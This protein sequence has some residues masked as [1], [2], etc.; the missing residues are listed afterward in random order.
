[1]PARHDP[2]GT[3]TADALVDEM[4]NAPHAIR[5]AI[6]FVRYGDIDVP[7]RI[8]DIPEAGAC[9]GA[10]LVV[11]FHGGFN[12]NVPY[13]FFY[14]QRFAGTEDAPPRTV[15]AL[16]DPTLAVNDTLRFGWFAGRAGFDVPA[17]VHALL[18]E[19]IGGIGPSRT[20]FAGGSIG[21]H[22]ALRHVGAFP[23]AV[24]VGLN[25][26]PRIS[27]YY[28]AGV[29]DFLRTCWP[30]QYD[31]ATLTSQYV[32][33][34]TGDRYD[35]VALTN[36]F[37]IVQNP[38]DPHLYQQAL[39]LLQKLGRNPATAGRVLGV[40]PYM[41]GCAGHGVPKGM[42]EQW[43]EAAIRAPGTSP[44]TIALTHDRLTRAEALPAAETVSATFGIDKQLAREIAARA[45]AWTSNV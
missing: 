22:A 36:D 5:R 10:P 32:E 8:M 23:D 13:P 2:P 37:V 45:S 31:A 4:R 19:V 43:V 6:R 30:G 7:V 35:G 16:C 11:V 9:S 24:F 18:R 1:M 29:E 17:A 34:D 41:A 15:L 33:D 21:A 44:D 28:R 3:V 26:L 39:P 14:G 40:M 12:R 42:F 27:I 25:P 20:L 38:T